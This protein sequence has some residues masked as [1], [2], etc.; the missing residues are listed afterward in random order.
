[1]KIKES[2]IAIVF[3]V[4]SIGC[5][6]GGGNTADEGTDSNGDTADEGTDSNGDTVTDTSGNGHLESASCAQYRG[7]MSEC[8]YQAR[9]FWVSGSS[10]GWTEGFG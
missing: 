9:R 5:S 3:L 6:K 8:G 2:I 4:V 1:M 10:V 7:F